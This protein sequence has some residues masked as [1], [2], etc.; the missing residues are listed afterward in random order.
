MGVKGPVTGKIR[1]A[2][3]LPK[4]KSGPSMNVEKV[5]VPEPKFEAFI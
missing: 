2:V 3:T 5:N 1:H 4:T